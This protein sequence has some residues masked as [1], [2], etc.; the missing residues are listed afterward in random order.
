LYW[1]ADRLRTEAGA[2]ASIGIR[3]PSAS[4][5]SMRYYVR[6]CLKLARL[7]TQ[8]SDGADTGRNRDGASILL[9]YAQNRLGV[10]V[11]HV[12]RLKREHDTFLL[13]EAARIRTACRIEVM[14]CKHDYRV[15]LKTHDERMKGAQR[16]G[17]AKVSLEVGRWND[18][19]TPYQEALGPQWALLQFSCSLQDEAETSLFDLGFQ[20]PHI[21][22]LCLERVKSVTAMVFVAD[23]FKTMGLGLPKQVIED[24]NAHLVM[25]TVALEALRDASRG[26]QLWQ[27]LTERQSKSL[28]SAKKDWEAL[29]SSIVVPLDPPQGVTRSRPLPPKLPGSN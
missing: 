3:W 23:A 24:V 4:A 15:G 14:R 26:S 12:S 6:L 2:L 28:Q 8:F 16:I 11:R 17:S 1:V 22:R 18:E 7:I 25:A 21:R 29:N 27:R 19:S 10:Y 20:R 13:L 5:R 9:E